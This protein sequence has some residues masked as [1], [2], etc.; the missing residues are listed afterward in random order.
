MIQRSSCGLCGMNE[1]RTEKGKSELDDDR[2]R[3]R[4]GD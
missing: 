4:E 1:E 2:E 3:G